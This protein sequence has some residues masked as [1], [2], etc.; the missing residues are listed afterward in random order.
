[1]QIIKYR[2]RLLYAQLLH[3]LLAH[4]RVQMIRAKN[5]FPALVALAQQCSGSIALTHLSHASHT[6]ATTP[7]L[8]A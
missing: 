2:A 8:T 6:R 7:Q 1:M 4:Y 5:L 3:R